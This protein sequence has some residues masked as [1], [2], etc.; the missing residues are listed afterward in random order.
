[1]QR[2][3]VQLSLGS[4]L[5]MMGSVLLV[6]LLI[7]RQ[8]DSHFRTFI[9]QDQLRDSQ[10]V[11]RLEEHYASQG[12]WQG[13][14]QLL[15]ARALAPGGHGQGQGL[16]LGRPDLTLADAEGHI[17]Y[18]DLAT[19]PA[20][21]LDRA[22]MEQALPLTGQDQT[23]GYLV[24]QSPQAAVL[25][26]QASSFLAQVNQALLR[27]ALVASTLGVLFGLL[28]ARSVIK[29]LDG[30]AAAARQ[31]AQGH[32]DQRVPLTGSAE[33][34]AL[35][36]SFNT[37]AEA[38]HQSEQ[39]RQ[40][41]VADLA[42]DLRTPLSVIQGNLQAML[43]GVY[44]L[45]Q[46]EL[47]II[48][49]ETILLSRLIDDLREL[50]RADAG[51]LQ[52]APQPLELLPILDHTA[53][54]FAEQAEAKQIALTVHAA[55]GLPLVLA[56]ADRLRQVL[57]NLLSNAL[58]Y[59]PAGGQI[60]ITAGAVPAPDYAA[61]PPQTAPA[62]H[63]APGYVQVA[64]RDTGVGIAREDLPYV[65]Q[66]LWRADRARA[67]DRDGSGSGLG[68]AIAERLVAA[69]GGRIGVESKAGHG[70]RFWFTLPAACHQ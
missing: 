59:T 70:S 17:I 69:Q 66:R 50:A 13:V 36:A 8:V 10:I 56:D 64:V 63:A 26:Q 48:Y 37:M 30:L 65:F 3:W 11:T 53:A 42:H 61:A 68:L 27:A 31:I 19:S 4:A 57:R 15:L 34:A 40:R 16:R 24:V 7:N 20:A 23:I 55:P 43:D 46:A 22:D 39:A 45:E 67:R 35:A 5:I 9:A 49:D 62:G 12:S 51:Q 41:L 44:P 32:L 38:L 60:T 58:R 54:I 21:A 18:S 47:A 25:S 14:E 28:L 52:I 33:I 6:S 29:P 1:M 2:L